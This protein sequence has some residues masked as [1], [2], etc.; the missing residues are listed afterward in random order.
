MRFVTSE[1][2]DEN[3]KCAVPPTAMGQPF[4]EPV[5]VMSYREEGARNE[6]KKRNERACVFVTNE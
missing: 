5:I 1:H 2:R 6:Q 4:F 3:T